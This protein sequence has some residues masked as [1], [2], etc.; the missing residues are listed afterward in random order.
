M[1]RGSSRRFMR[2]P[3]SFGRT[4]DVGIGLPLLCGVLNG[5]D[6][7]LITRAAAKIARDP[8]AY[9]A[10]GG[11][12]VVLQQGDSG[13]DHARRAVAAL[14]AVLLPET[15]L[16]RVQLALWREPLDRRDCR[17]IGLDREH[18]ARFH[19]SAIDE[20]SASAALTRVAADMRAG[21]P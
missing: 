7:V 19:A 20:N 11:R 16:Q 5:V 21:Q 4:G 9:F 17:S 13:H 2:W 8:L 18:G 3:T 14:Q 15:F 1:R 6:D 12:G 10:F